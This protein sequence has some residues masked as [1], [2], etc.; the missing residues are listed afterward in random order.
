M[1]V[2]VI[3]ILGRY[4]A[5]SFVIAMIGLTAVLGWYAVTTI[6]MNADTGGML[7]RELPRR[8]VAGGRSSMP[9][10]FGTGDR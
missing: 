6:G 8:F 5:L 4:W 10:R 9:P 7:S 3:R 2:R 1:M